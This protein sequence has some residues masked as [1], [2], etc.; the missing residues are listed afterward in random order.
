MSTAP[1]AHGDN[2]LFNAIS[3]FAAQEIGTRKSSF[4]IQGMLKL[5]RTEEDTEMLFR[6]ESVLFLHFRKELREA[7]DGRV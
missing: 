4:F 6:V 3:D 7:L 2:A 1:L 5:L